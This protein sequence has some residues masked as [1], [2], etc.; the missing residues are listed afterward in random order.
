MNMENERKKDY[1]WLYIAGVTIVLVGIIGMAKLSENEKYDPIRQQL[2]EEAA[3][4][5]IRVLK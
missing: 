5:N 2:N 4:M 3:Q 1:F